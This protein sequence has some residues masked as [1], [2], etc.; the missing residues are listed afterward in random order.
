MN[1]SHILFTQIQRYQQLNS[2]VHQRLNKIMLVETIMPE[3][4]GTMR[5][6]ISS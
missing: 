2:Y 3:E 4:F 6:L 1:N 5:E